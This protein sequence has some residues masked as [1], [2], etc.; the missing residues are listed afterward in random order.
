L[1]GLPTN[2]FQHVEPPQKLEPPLS[3]RQSL[4]EPGSQ[5]P[6]EPPDPPDPEVEER[7]RA[8]RG[9]R[10]IAEYERRKKAALSSR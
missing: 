1:W 6:P 9:I 10:E 3:I 7:S 2:F 4:R 8:M 5:S